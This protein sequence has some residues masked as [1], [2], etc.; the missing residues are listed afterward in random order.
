MKDD[1]ELPA[2]EG[3]SSEEENETAHFGLAPLRDL[4]DQVVEVVEV[5][6]LDGIPIVYV[7]HEDGEPR[8]YICSNE[9]AAAGATAIQATLKTRGGDDG[10]VVK[11][12]DHR[13]SG[14]G[15]KDERGEP[16]T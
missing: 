7:A 15:F 10:V 13:I 8:G 3:D 1:L 4:V 14:V 12:I 6:D 16:T 9:W 5:E 2:P 11:V